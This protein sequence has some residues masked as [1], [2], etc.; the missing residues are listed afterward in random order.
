MTAQDGPSSHDSAKPGRPRDPE[1]S[2]AIL[3]ATVRVL[4]DLGYAGA[5]MERVAAEAGVGKTTIYRRYSSKEE[6][7]AAALG[8]I[9]DDLGD[10]PDTGCART[11]VVDMAAQTQAALRRGPGLPLVGA[12]LV[13]ERRNP[14]LFDLLRERFLRPRRRDVI[15][16]LRRGVNRGEIREDVDLEL[17]ANAI[18]G[19][20]LARHI[21]DGPGSRKRIEETVDTIWRGL[22]VD[23]NDR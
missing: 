14:S 20:V 12:L 19:L 13:E 16:V 6:L 22:G 8:S 1:V 21:L 15:S 18:V 9:R 23:R 17:G 3:R 10:P 7:V 4:T 2:K 5:S 11:D